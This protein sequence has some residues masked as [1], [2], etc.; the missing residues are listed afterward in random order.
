MCK[1]NNDSYSSQTFSF[2]LMLFY[3]SILFPHAWKEKLEQAF[4]LHWSYI[5]PDYGLDTRRTWEKATQTQSPLQVCWSLGSVPVQPQVHWSSLP[6]ANSF[7]LKVMDTEICS[8]SVLSWT[9]GAEG[10]IPLI[11]RFLTAWQALYHLVFYSGPN[12]LPQT[13]TQ[14]SAARNSKDQAV[15]SAHKEKQALMGISIQKVCS[16]Y[17]SLHM[18]VRTDAC[19]PL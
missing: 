16:I 1:F 13:A 17:L 18:T 5:K 7:I 3:F 12:Y 11:C 10:L 19:R 15:P 8:K 2:N 9:V 6:S 4:Q 14:L